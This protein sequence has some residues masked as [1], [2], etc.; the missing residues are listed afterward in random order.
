M[1]QYEMFELRF[2]G[3]APEGSRV[4]VDL[5]AEFVNGEKKVY[6]KGFYAGNEEYVI[7][8]YPTETGIYKYQVTGVIEASG[9][10]E[11]DKA[12]EKNHGIVTAEGTHFR[13]EDG[14]WYYP[15]G[16][17]VYALLHQ[18][19]ELIN[20]TMETLEQAPFNKIRIC[21]F[22]KYFDYNHNDPEYY[23]FE[24]IAGEW[25]VH[26]PCFE[27]WNR[28]E[29]RIQQLEQ[30]GIQCDLILFHPYDK[31]GFATLK[32]EQA[33]VY[34]DYLA[35][36][37][38]AFPN[39]WW[40]LANEYDIMGY[41]KSDW[42]CF[43][44]FMHENDSYGHLLSNH[45]MITPWDFANEDT[46]HICVQTG[47]LDNIRTD[48][49]KYRKPMMVD[50]CGYEG[51]IPMN[52]GNLSA[53]ELVN[54]F[55]K[56]YMQGAYCT[57]G[58]TFENDEELLWWSKGGKLQGESPARIRFLKEIVD[59]IQGPLEDCVHVMTLEVVRALKENPP[60]EFAASA[61]FQSLLNTEDE[62]VAELEASQGEFAC[63]CGEEV[64]MK[65][66]DRHCTCRGQL[67]LPKTGKYNVEVIDTWEMTKEITMELVSGHVE[68]KLPGKEGIAVLARKISE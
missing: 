24:K 28:I 67:D 3:N 66:Y 38:S 19:D 53:Y 10:L 65:Y 22:P 43:A 68:V 35:R 48:I 50:E 51:N 64:Y 11:C 56:V 57:H 13:F 32:Q 52:W 4:E 15:F 44:H 9:E 37:L 55:W 60:V 26:H 36:R 25:D 45:H 42:E 23:A 8:F 6:V 63:H 7:R 20:Q 27:F 62:M 41:E 40:S 5:T 18:E 21:M 14:T 29:R 46:T 58:E 30:L 34:L 61:M 17:T 49:S 59:S 12:D 33:L 54:R 16:T 2:Q 47:K 1:K 31:W 39:V